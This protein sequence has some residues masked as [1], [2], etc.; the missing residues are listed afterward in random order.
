MFYNVPNCISQILYIIN[1]K[2]LVYIEKKWNI[3]KNKSKKLIIT[4]QKENDEKLSI[5]YEMLL[6]KNIYKSYIYKSFKLTNS[7][8]HGKNPIE[9]FLEEL[10]R[11]VNNSKHSNKI[12]FFK[13]IKY[14]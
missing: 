2:W 7:Q 5:S 9:H 4:K 3:K 11:N 13:I 14:K 10:K 1:S 6:K 12:K 8:I